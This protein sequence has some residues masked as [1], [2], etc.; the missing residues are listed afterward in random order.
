VTR[1]ERIAIILV[2][3][4]VGG[5]VAIFVTHTLSWLNGQLAFSAG[6]NVIQWISGPAT[7]AA[8][9]AVLYGYFV[10][11]CAMPFCVRRGEHPVD[12]TLK[13]VCHEHHTRGH[14]ERVFDLFRH[15]HVVSGRLDWGQ[16]HDG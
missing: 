6:A 1:S 7:L 11:R 5:F 13:K 9:V 14:H 15:E 8:V 12:G 4:V 3:F 10:R 16:S 2:A